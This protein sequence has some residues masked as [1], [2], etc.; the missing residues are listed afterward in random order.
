MPVGDS[1][2]VYPQH[3]VTKDSECKQVCTEHKC[4]HLTAAA[5]AAT[6]ATPTYNDDRLLLLFLQAAGARQ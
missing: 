1:T 4:T 2:E 6:V 3:A 5:A